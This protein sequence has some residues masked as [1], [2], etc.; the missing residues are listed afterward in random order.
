LNGTLFVS[1]I[2]G[3]TDPQFTGFGSKAAGKMGINRSGFGVL[4]ATFYAAP[5]RGS[6]AAMFTRL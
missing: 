6:A 5:E 2:T 4:G 1:N 3:R